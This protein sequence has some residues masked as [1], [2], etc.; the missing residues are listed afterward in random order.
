M[1]GQ[2]AAR[3]WSA[4][5]SWCALRVE[6]GEPG[7]FLAFEEREQD[8]VRNVASLGFNLS[9]LM[10]RKLIAL[11]RIHVDRMEIEESAEYDS[12]GCSR[13]WRWRSTRSGRSA[14]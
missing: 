10:E 11:D 14:W 8:L 5:T 9:D 4:C 1:A 7:V 3:R 13:A 6:H 12:K 2:V